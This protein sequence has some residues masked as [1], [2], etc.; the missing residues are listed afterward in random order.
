MP[1]FE[2]PGRNYFNEDSLPPVVLL[3]ASGATVAMSA[4]NRDIFI[5]NTAVI[6]ALT[7]KLPRPV[8]GMLARLQA[9]NDITAITWED[10]RGQAVGGLPTGT[11]AVW[12]VLELRYIS[13]AVGWV[14]MVYG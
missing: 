8:P 9:R 10:Y 2:N 7:I 1:S 4:G 6:A 5:N 14:H 12:Q 11:T 3:P 13:L